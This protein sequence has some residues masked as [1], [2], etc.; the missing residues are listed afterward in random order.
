M[1]NLFC[2]LC[3]S[4]V[5]CPSIAVTLT[6]APAHAQAVSTDLTAIIADAREMIQTKMRDQGI[7]GYAAGIYANGRVQWVDGFGYADLESRSP[8]WPS[9]RFR[10]GSVSK[11]FTAAALGRL[12][13]ERRLDLD[14]P[15]QR[16]VPGFPEKRAPVSTRQLAGHLAG[17]RHYRGEEFLS[18]RAY[19]SVT[20][21]L[22]IFDDDT[23]L[24]APGERYSYSSYGWNLISAVIEGA[25]GEPFVD[26]MV[27]T[28]FQPLDMHHTGP[29]RVDSIV[30]QRTA[31]YDLGPD[32]RLR[33]APHVDNSVKWAGGGFLSSVEDL[34]KFGVAH[35][36][37]G[38][39]DQ[40]TLETLFT[41]QR[42]NDGEATDY[43]IGWGTERDADTGRWR[44]WHTGGSVG[45]TTALVLYPEEGV[46][47]AV[48]A[49]MSSV[50]GQMATALALAEMFAGW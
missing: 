41:S 34:L 3:L 31:F 21:A 10:I 49:N 50:D 20:E 46:V 9:T 33:N 25:T 18:A 11:S 40:E 16:Y 5:L 14:A 13:G 2:F 27:R 43:G 22:E 44:V 42:T 7:P 36:E 29:D 12:L 35:L 17:V 26:Y 4:C 38:F 6:P 15:V 24:F 48:I 30:A 37:P 28:I 19:A 8:V 39:L 23:L 45:G 1:Q 47:A 32:D